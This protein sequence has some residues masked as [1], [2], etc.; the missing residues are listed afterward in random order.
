MNLEQLKTALL[1]NWVS[2][3]P[4]VRPS[5]NPDGTIKPFYLKR[6]FAYFAEDRFELT[7]INYADPFGKIPLA[8]IDIAGHM[9]WRGD[10]PIAPGAQKVDFLADEAYAV[11]PQVQGFADLLNKVAAN[12]YAKWEVGQ[13]QSIF[14]KSFLPFG[15]VEGRNFMECDLVHLAHDMMFWGARNVDG[16]GFDQEENRPTN[17]QIPMIRG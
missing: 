3:A 7:V 14:G 11:T 9:F 8:K 1:G 17:L 16:R 15:L 6:H 12:G 13:T 10:H 4:E 5:K 2:L